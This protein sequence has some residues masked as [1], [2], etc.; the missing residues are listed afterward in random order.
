MW[1]EITTAGG[2]VLKGH[3][4]RKVENHCLGVSS[5]QSNRNSG[6]SYSIVNRLAVW[7]E[8]AGKS[9]RVKSQTRQVGLEKKVEELGVFF[10][11]KS[12]DWPVCVKGFVHE[13][14]MACSPMYTSF[15][16]KKN[17]FMD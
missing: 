10:E 11:G 9:C 14:Q 5:R 2:T 12:H 7:K 1:L 13:S 15:N 16:R 8:T 3:S 17:S 6:N 4:I